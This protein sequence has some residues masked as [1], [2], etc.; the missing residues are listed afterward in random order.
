MQASAL[1]IS[2]QT[3]WK[4][5]KAMFGVAV[6]QSGIPILVPTATSQNLVP[7][8]R[9]TAF[10][11]KRDRFLTCS[12]VLPPNLSSFDNVHLL[13]MSHSNGPKARVRITDLL[14]RDENLDFA[15]MKGTLVQGLME[16]V[17]IDFRD[18]VIGEDVIAVGF[19]LPK[20]RQVAAA[21]RE[22]E[23]IL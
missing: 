1:P 18:P 4:A 7:A 9:G 10:A 19:P 20:E 12:H 22:V 8:M 2:T 15:L 6:F 16:P 17:E 13:G 3:I 11:V 14:A 21:N 23:L 5:T